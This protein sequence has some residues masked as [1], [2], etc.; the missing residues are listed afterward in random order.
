MRMK[1]RKQGKLVEISPLPP[2]INIMRVWWKGGVRIRT[3]EFSPLHLLP[4]YKFCKG[5]EAGV[6]PK[7]LEFS[8]INPS[9]PH[10]PPSPPN[11]FMRV[12]EGGNGE[13]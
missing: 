12:G 2:P 10:T 11:I 4:P 5:G 9:S 13:N 1:R 8:L 3:M 6:W 7:L